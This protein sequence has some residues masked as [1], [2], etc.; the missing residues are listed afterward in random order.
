MSDRFRPPHCNQHLMP[1]LDDCRVKATQMLVSAGTNGESVRWPS[2]AEYSE[3]A[4]NHQAQR[5]RYDT[6]GVPDAGPLNVHHARLMV[7]HEFGFVLSTPDLTFVDIVDGLENGYCFTLSG[8]PSNINPPSPL[9]RAGNVGHEFYLDRLGTSGDHVLVYDPY[10]D[11]GP[12]RR[13]E[14]RPI[15]ELRQFSREFRDPD[16]TVV[17]TR[18]RKG[19]WREAAEVKR[20]MAKRID[21]MRDQR[22][23]QMQ[24]VEDQ[25]GAIKALRDDF[26]AVR[27]DTL[28]KVAEKLDELREL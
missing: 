6:P 7:E 15:K 20:D 27:E 19:A 28:D 16:G 22:D 26:R 11:V 13:G 24:I 8:D 17:C 3:R 23:E 9:R 2:G 4:L 1:P 18:V 25:R 5:M 21:K 10:R 14:W 12:D